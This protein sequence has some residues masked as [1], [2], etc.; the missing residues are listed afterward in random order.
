MNNVTKNNLRTQMNLL[1]SMMKFL[2]TILD[3]TQ[4][5]PT[6]QKTLAVTAEGFFDQAAVLFRDISAYTEALAEDSKR[7]LQHE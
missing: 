7:V 3:L 5:S 1:F 2:S 4:D 6:V